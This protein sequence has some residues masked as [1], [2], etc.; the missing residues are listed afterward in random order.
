MGKPVLTSNADRFQVGGRWGG[1]WPLDLKLF[2]EVGRTL[3]RMD[4]APTQSRANP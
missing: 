1:G 2:R 3:Q 4:E